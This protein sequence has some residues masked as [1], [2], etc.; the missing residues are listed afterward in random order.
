MKVDNGDTNS[1]LWLSEA[2]LNYGELTDDALFFFAKIK[3]L[4]PLIK[5]YL[6]YG[7]FHSNEHKL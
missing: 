3:K 2:C 5:T 6:K 4:N 1:I 7:L